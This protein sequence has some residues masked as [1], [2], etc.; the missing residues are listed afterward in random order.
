M[1]SKFGQLLLGG[2][3]AVAVALPASAET[4]TVWSRQTDQSISVLKAITDAFTKETGIKVETFNSGID[5]EQRLARAAAARQLPDVVINDSSQVGSMRQ[6]GIL[7]PIDRTK[8]AGWKDVSD[9]AWQSAQDGQGNYY[10]VPISAQAFAL[11]VR[12][13]WREKLGLPVPKT[14]DDMRKLAEAFTH[15]DPDGNGKADTFGLAIP[16]STTR[17]YASWY[18]SHFL[19]QA[20]GG[21]LKKTKD[22][23]LPI[24]N[25][26]EDAKALSFVRGLICDGLAQP[27]AVNA[28]TGDTLPTFRSGQTGM[29]IDGPYDLGQIAKEPGL[30]KTEVDI[31]PAGPSGVA[32]LA[33][34]TS[35]YMLKG[36]TDKAAVMK[37]LDFLISPEGQKIGMNVGSD[38]T[39]LVRLPVNT[40]MDVLKIRKDPRWKVYQDT[41]LNY[42]HYMPA[43][44]DWTSIRLLTGDG[45]NAILS[46]CQ[47][48]IPAQL[49]DLNT[50]VAA[51]LKKQGV[52]DPSYKE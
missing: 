32:A 30:D 6:M 8:L 34:G 17:G 1:K 33:E 5:F 20:G 16:A 4:I 39:P 41:F 48:D 31:L 25:T 21:Y 42:G 45:F 51:E 7:D 43:V 46:Q 15:D 14:W 12:K 10:A 35:A 11:F 23:F 36:T 22:G 50:K 44:P 13:D 27:G 40:T 3:L 52:L 37:F 28:T 49:A 18:M 24:L 9:I 38:V 26:P 2:C 29:L 47:S 19:W